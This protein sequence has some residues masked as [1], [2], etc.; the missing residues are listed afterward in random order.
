M[1]NPILLS[2]SNILI[3]FF[4]EN[5]NNSYDVKTFL[6][7]NKKKISISTLIVFISS[8]YFFEYH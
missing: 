4:Y 7:I 5:Y 8:I 2:L 6:S 1:I 3:C